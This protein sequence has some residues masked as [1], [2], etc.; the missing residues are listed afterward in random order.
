MKPRRRVPFL[1]T[2]IVVDAVAALHLAV[3]ASVGAGY[4]RAVSS[5]LLEEAD[6]EGMRAF[7]EAVGRQ[8]ARSQVIYLIVLIFNIVALAFVV[9]SD[10]QLRAGDRP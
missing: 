3:D 5:Q 10:R 2:L 7:L 1:I 9:D 8:S 4:F 6:Y